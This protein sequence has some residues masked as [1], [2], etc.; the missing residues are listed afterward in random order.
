MLVLLLAGPVWIA[1]PSAGSSPDEASP[2]KVQAS[3]SKSPQLAGTTAGAR[4]PEPGRFSLTSNA[5]SALVGEVTNVMVTGGAVASVSWDLDPAAI[6]YQILT[7]TSPDFGESPPFETVNSAGPPLVDSQV[8]PV[9]QALFIWVR[10]QDDVGDFGTWGSQSDGTERVMS[11]FLEITTPAD[12]GIVIVEQPTIGVSYSDDTAVDTGTLAFTANSAPLAV[13]CNLDAFGGTC[14]PASPLPSSLITLEA[15]VDDLDGNTTTRQIA[16]TV[17]TL[18]AS[19]DITS[20]ADGLIT[21]DPQIDMTGSV[22]PDTVS[23]D[24]N[25]VTAPIVGG[26]F[27][28]TVPLREGTNM[29]VALATKTSG[30][31]GTDSVEVTRDIVAP[32][33][34][35]TSPGDGFDS[36]E[37]LI[38]VTGQVNDIVNGATDPAV[39]VNGVPATVAGGS[40]MVMDL[41]LVR[42]PNPIVAVATDA[43]GNQGSHAI[44]VNFVQ[45]AGVR[46]NVESGNGQ[47]APTGGTLGAPLGVAVRDFL[48]NPVAGRAVQFE[49]SR[50]NGTLQADAGDPPQ[51]I[52]QVTSD[53]SGLASVLFT[54]G[55]TAGEGNN[56]VLVSVVG[57]AGQVEFCASAL[58]TGP[59]KI[60]MVSGDNQRGVVSHPLANPLETLVVDQDGNPINN[61]DVTFTVVQGNGNLNGQASLVRVTGVDGIARAVFTLGSDPGI[62][63]NVVGAT[64]PGLAGLAATF[65]VSGLAPGNPANTSFSGVVLDNGHTPIPGALV[66]IQGT[67]ASTTTDAEGQFLLT[68]VPVGHIVLNIDPTTS[69]RPETFPPLAFETVTVA[70][71]TNILGQPILIPALDTLNSKLV[72]GNQ[73]VTIQM[74]GVAGLELTVFANSVTFPD[75]STTGQLTIS[76]VHLDKVPMPPPSGTIFMPPAWTIQPSGVMFDPPARI[77]IPNDGLPPGRVIDIFQFDHTLNQFINV[78]KGTVSNDGLVIVSDPGFGITR[79]GWGGCGQPQPPQTC[80]S[81]CDDGNRCTTD[82]CVNGSCVH[83]PITTA[84][85]AANMCEGCNNGT[86]VPKK[87]N[88]ECCAEISQTSGYILCCNATKIVCVGTDFPGGNEGQNIIRQCVI[89]HEQEHTTQGD[90]CPTGANECTTTGP[91]G[92]P[93]GGNLAQ[94]ECDA[95]K[96]EVACLQNS[97][98]SNQACQDIVDTGI[99]DAKNYGN[100]FV[101]DCFPP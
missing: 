81:S 83:T 85:S 100:G 75:D 12:G 65:V 64:F 1:A 34:V 92:P 4:T 48:G 32:T 8:P 15:S 24:V 94:D 47:S 10:A 30:R 89:A 50:N 69:P 17:D 20:P 59:E 74:S 14:V 2:T 79:A 67:A 9:G 78:G 53:G 84:P 68:N 21:V 87:T 62:N 3:D 61:I 5:P 40:F 95:T 27:S 25:G 11:P 99:V 77:S 66:T 22:G 80:T 42:G 16:F 71:Q 73:N 93:P 72:G 23:V 39:T 33:V 35:I 63:N 70:G 57:V 58:A 82:T 52:V 26:A 97:N 51:R 88:A 60:L 18:P 56:R 7:S 46:I 101:A 91:L 13:N 55:D 45:P 6:V 41:P 54:L 29:L 49:V 36:T 86:P 90:P 98:C 37:D 31:T 19:I 28:A 96:V 43:V 44:N 76:Q 38:A